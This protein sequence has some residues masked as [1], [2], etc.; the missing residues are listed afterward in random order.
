MEQI[1]ASKN[2]TSVNNSAL[3]IN[4]LSPVRIFKVE[5]QNQISAEFVFET[6]FVILGSIMSPVSVL[7]WFHNFS[8][9][10]KFCGCKFSFSESSEV[11][12]ITVFRA[13]EFTS[14]QV[15]RIFGARTR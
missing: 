1:S 5:G 11:V 15:N 12:V 4:V 9:S 14:I 8:L 6:G 10:N 7:Y 2:D 13:S 3:H